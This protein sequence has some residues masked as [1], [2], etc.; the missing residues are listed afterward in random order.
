MPSSNGTRNGKGDGKPQKNDKEL[1]ASVSLPL[2]PK[3]C[4]F[5]QKFSGDHLEKLRDALGSLGGLVDEGSAGNPLLGIFRPPRS[6]LHVFSLCRRFG[7]ESFIFSLVDL[8]V[9]LLF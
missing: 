3:K 1:I 4:H 6:L 7:V 8:F 9:L 2:R 5:R